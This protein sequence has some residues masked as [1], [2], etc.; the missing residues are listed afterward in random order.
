MLE[1]IK[2]VLSELT[3][4]A[5]S[6]A[7]T[8]A[9][10][11]IFLQ[12]RRR[13]GRSKLALRLRET[14]ISNIYASRD[15]YVRYRDAGDLPSFL[16]LAKKSVTIIGHWMAQGTEIQGVAE[17]IAALVL[18]PKRLKVEIALVN[19]R[20][21]IVPAL[22]QYLGLSEA[23]TTS[24]IEQSLMKLHLARLR[25]GDE[26]RKRMRLLVYDTLPVASIIMLD[27]DE[28]SGRIQVDVKLFKQ[29]RQHSFTFE[30]RGSTPLYSRFRESWGHI[31]QGAEVFD[32]NKHLSSSAIRPGPSVNT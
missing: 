28:A 14:G 1:W 23:E 18:P 30:V 20:S 17:S 26:E 29:P 11:W 32:A 27:P 15:D 10:T 2:S 24:R 12:Y 16:S 21:A 25:L 22:A 13:R 5:I 4:A 6:A 31:V 19:P 8:A 3:V 9:G 7:I